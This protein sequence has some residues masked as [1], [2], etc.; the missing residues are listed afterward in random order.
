MKRQVMGALRQEFR[1]EFLNRVDEIIVF[2]GLTEADLEKIVGLL[3]PRSPEAARRPRP[4]DHLTPSAEAVIAREGS[5]PAYGARPLKRTI[6]RLVE[7]PLARALLRGEFRPGAAITVDAD[8]IG[9]TLVFRSEETTVVAD[10][11]ERR[12]AR[13][14]GLGDEP[15]TAATGHRQASLTSRRPTPP[16]KDG[17]DDGGPLLN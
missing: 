3:L 4:L 16:K 5:D 2:H 10:A 7:N 15:A 14:A 12:D 6:Q 1:P 11:G 13:T 8:P 17:S 9:G